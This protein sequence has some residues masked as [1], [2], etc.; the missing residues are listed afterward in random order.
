M[1]QQTSSLSHETKAMI[2]ESR[3]IKNNIAQFNENFNPKTV[4]AMIVNWA[5]EHS[6][7]NYRMSKMYVVKKDIKANGIQYKRGQKLL[8][9]PQ[10]VETREINFYNKKTRAAMKNY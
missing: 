9:K 1:L 5:K 2:L 4:G 6:E 10:N 7:L 3:F 8:E